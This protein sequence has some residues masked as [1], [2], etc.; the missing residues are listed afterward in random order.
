MRKNRYLALRVILFIGFMAVVLY[1]A[2][3]T[4]ID[5]NNAYILTTLKDYMIILSITFLIFF[6]ELDKDKIREERLKAY[7]DGYEQGQYDKDMEAE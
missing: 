6:A 5:H 1:V 2:T 3:I 7:K 4:F